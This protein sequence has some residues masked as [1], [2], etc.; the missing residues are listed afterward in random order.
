[1]LSPVEDLVLQMTPLISGLK[2]VVKWWYKLP[3]EVIVSRKAIVTAATTMMAT[4]KTN[5]VVALR[6]IRHKRK[7]EE[8]NKGLVSSSQVLRDMAAPKSPPEDLLTTPFANCFAL[9][10]HHPS[11]GPAR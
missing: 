7:L 1:M 11:L 8:E 10:P 3:L 4:Y 6:H 9:E 5:Y 2:T